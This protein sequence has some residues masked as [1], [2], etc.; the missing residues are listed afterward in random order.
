LSSTRQ[1]ALAIALGVG[2]LSAAPAVAQVTAQL[3]GGI[4]PAWE[5]GIQPINRDNYWNAVECGKQGGEQP[6]CVFYDTGLCKNDDFTLA[7]FTPYKLVSYEVWRVVRLHQPAPTP[8]YQAAERTRVT[9]GIKPVAGGK[10]P[11]ASVVIKRDDRVVK[12]AT[13]S[14]DAGGGNFIFD[15]AA[16]ASTADI[17]IEMTGRAKTVSCLVPR[18]V[19]SRFR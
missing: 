5:K 16:F 3:P 9:L 15:P 13:Q 14:L 1:A 10:N 12:P 17:T 11:I 19:L 4:A 2:V 18:D 7:L 6:L 8:S